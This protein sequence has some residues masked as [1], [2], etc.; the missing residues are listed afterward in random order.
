MARYYGDT[1]KS[2]ALIGLALERLGWTL[3]GWHKDDS[4]MQTD[5]YA[6]QHWD[7]V[8]TKG[9]Y[10][11]CVDVNV[12]RVTSASGGQ[13]LNRPA[14]DQE[15]TRCHG[16]KADPTGWTF[17]KARENPLDFNNDTDGQAG[18]ALF[19]NVV[20]PL[21]FFGCGPQGGDY[22]EELFGRERCRKCHGSGCTWKQV[23]YIEP[24]PTFQANPP[25]RNWHL[26]T[27]GVIIASGSGV[28]SCDKAKAEV[29]AQKIDHLAGVLIPKPKIY[30]W[31]SP[32]AWLHDA[33]QEWDSERLASEVIALASRL[34]SDALQDEYQADMD[35]DDY[36]SPVE[37]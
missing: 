18:R 27:A 31:G 17:D 30:R 9:E 22:P 4:D 14:P 35:A 11:A 28:G 19:R 21:G 32:L 29:L 8:A 20:S 10:V 34:D 24:W 1:Q 13:T 36:F 23:A 2:I 16:A 33:V 15:C 26:E 7:G 12:Y 6:P 37:E 3:Y 25:N 5:Y